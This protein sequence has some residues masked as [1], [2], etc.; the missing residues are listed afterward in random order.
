MYFEANKPEDFLKSI[1][2]AFNMNVDEKQKMVQNA[3]DFLI[4]NNYLSILKKEIQDE[5]K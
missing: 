5:K 3:Q 4:Q 2:K 1:L